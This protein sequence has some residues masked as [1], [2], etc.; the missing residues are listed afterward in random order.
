LVGGCLALIGNFVLPPGTCAAPQIKNINLR[1]IQAGG[2]TVLT[3]DGEGLTPETRL[4][5]GVPIAGQSIKPGGNDKRIEVEVSLPEKVPSGLYLLRV[6]NADGVSNGVPVGVDSLNQSEIGDR[7]DS[8]PAALSG[9]ISGEQSARTKFVAKK[10]ET[11]TVEVE[12]R[13]LLSELNPVIHLYDA[14]GV[15][16]AWAQ[17]T[18]R[19]V[20][21]ARL[22]ATIPADGEY[23][24]ELH[25][26]LYQGR[27]SGHFRLKIGQFT[28]ADLAYPTAIKQG[29]RAT[30]Q[31]LGAS[32]P[33][34]TSVEVD[35]P[36]QAQFFPVPSAEGL[37]FTGIRPALWASEFDEPVETP[38]SSSDL[39]TIA[40]PSG[41]HGRLLAHGEEDRF[42]VTV[43]GG[44]K[45]RIEV[46]AIRL[47]SPIDA[48][49]TVYDSSG[50]NVLSTND[51]QPRMSDA[52]L[53]FT[54]PADAKDFVVGLKD[55]IGRGGEDCI[56]RLT[57]VP[58]DRPDFLLA[59]SED[60]VNV[61]RGG[62]AL[63][64]LAVERRGYNGPI[65][66]AFDGLPTGIAVENAQIPAGSNIGLLLL[67]GVGDAADYAAIRLIGRASE[68][69]ASGELMRTA[70]L[71]ANALT[72]RQPWLREELAVALTKPAPLQLAWEPANDSLPLGG[73]LN[74]T[75]K[76]IRGEGVAGP[77]RLALVTTQQTPKKTIKENNQDKQVDDVERSLRLEG[78]PAVA[79]E[80]TESAV[81]VIVPADLPDL[82]YSL[83][84]R[85][86]LLSAD[87]MQVLATAYAPVV[88][89][90]PA[91]PVSLALTSSET[92]DARSGLGETG[93]F[94]GTIARQ[95]TFNHPLRVT[96]EGLPPGVPP[97]FADVAAD[98]NAFE[99]AVRLP[100]GLK[101][102]PLK[103]V[104]LVAVSLASPGDLGNAVRTN[105]VPVTLNVVSGERPPIEAPLK[106]FEDEEEFTT[107]LNQG[108]GQ[109][110]LEGGQKYSGAASV[111]VT[112]DQ[113]FNPAL[114][115][116][117]VKIRKDPGPGEYRYLRFVWRKQGGN[118]IC[119][120]LN[121][122]GA[123]GPTPGGSA[124]S[125][126][127]HAG[128][129]ECYGASLRVNPRLPNRM[130]VVTRDLYA[131][132]GEFTLTGLALSPVD[133]QF[134]LYDHI[135]LGRTV[136]D[137]GS[138]KPEN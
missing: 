104:K 60:R 37:Q 124:A 46:Y 33:P 30:V 85:G 115:S 75:A 6:I 45:L 70:M 134:A 61:P 3:I 111:R 117:G 42:R 32:V 101:A 113:R 90:R 22:T 114:S 40:V 59:L 109:I 86:E 127:Y 93:T 72:E 9:S 24:L 56:Y 82:T 107:S 51:D 91:R 132:F 54:V 87:G 84:V 135:Y 8:L 112:P 18:Q 38:S 28:C 116:L 69:P 50:K 120:Q 128:P 136:D 13:R 131:D 20:G 126:R 58:Q 99:L 74:A 100:H 81:Q 49:L 26:A 17:G 130:T 119:L 138:V 73:K 15:Q 98:A 78:T 65:D 64:R 89:A 35:S 71:P 66:M 12:A 67:S 23:S 19:L 2:K 125:F 105:Q 4:V 97:P 122:D 62:R 52:G 41:I 121:H 77:V 55:L 21:D 118:Q 80:Q 36:H 79:A 94:T 14:R 95:A 1:G 7:A 25:D 102:A 48:V 39:Q 129:G 53:D 110:R 10:G 43:A 29:T 83:L 103:N 137:L 108:N 16:V 47:G 106:I 133:G 123:W 31:L 96:L 57:I 5:L 63:V 27:S 92:I 34:G 44:Q 68:Q 11:I 76:A 88:S